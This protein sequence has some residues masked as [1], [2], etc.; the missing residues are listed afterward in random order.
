MKK[1][2][3][4]L[5]LLIFTTDLSGQPPHTICNK[6]CSSCSS[7]DRNI[8]IACEDAYYMNLNTCYLCPTNCSTCKDDQSCKSCS[9]DLKLVLNK[10]ISEKENEINYKK[11]GLVSGGVIT[12]IIF[13]IFLVIWSR[14]K[15]SVKSQSSFGDYDDISQSGVIYSS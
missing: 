8:C 2:I 14:K 9:N 11:I 15:G 1:S 5:L 3:I 12:I 10:C 4:W 13:I 7:K 6:G